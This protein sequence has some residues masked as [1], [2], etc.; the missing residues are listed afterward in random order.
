M[1]RGYIIARIRV[2][3]GCAAAGAIRGAVA[4]TDPRI[5]SGV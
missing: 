4:G 1:P 2:R 5:I 3:A